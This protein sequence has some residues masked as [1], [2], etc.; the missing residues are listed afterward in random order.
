[1][2]AICFDARTIK[3]GK[4]HGSTPKEGPCDRY[5][6][7][8]DYCLISSQSDSWTKLAL[9]RHRHVIL[10]LFIRPY[11]TIKYVV[12]IITNTYLKNHHNLI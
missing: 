5:Q 2:Y 6:K 12:G 3:K 9:I 8:D 4:N 7:N 1:M 10:K 11:T